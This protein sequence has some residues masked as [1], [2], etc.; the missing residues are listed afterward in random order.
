MLIRVPVDMSVRV[1]GKH[2]EIGEALPE[3]VRKRLQSVIGKHFDGGADTHVV[4][5]HE[6][7]GFRADCSTHLDSGVVLKAEG[8]AL[9]AY[10]AFD[11]AVDKLEKQVRRYKRRLKN[12]H[13]KTKA[14][15]TQAT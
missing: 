10:R 15:R 9:D 14:L 11:A 13:E 7:A 8:L 1:S 4:F 6:G 12:H 5:S 2:L 3:Q